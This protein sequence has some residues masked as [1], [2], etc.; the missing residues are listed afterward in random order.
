MDFIDI[1]KELPS[2]FI[3]T[4]IM[5]ANQLEKARELE[6]LKGVEFPLESMDKYK[7]YIPWYTPTTIGVTP[8]GNIVFAIPGVPGE[9]KWLGNFLKSFYDKIY[10]NLLKEA[11]STNGRGRI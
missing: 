1:L 6:I 11:Q 9:E 8:E 3:V 10:P 4:G 7:K 2:N 5:P